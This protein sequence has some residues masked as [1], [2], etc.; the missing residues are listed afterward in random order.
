VASVWRLAVGLPE[1]H[2]LDL[3][4]LAATGAK[5]ATKPA[6]K[7]RVT[8][9]TSV[10]QGDSMVRSALV[11]KYY[12]HRVV[13]PS[14]I[15]L[16]AITVIALGWHLFSNVEAH[17]AGYIL[18]VLR[19]GNDCGARIS[20]SAQERLSH[21]QQHGNVASFA[22]GLALGRKQLEQARNAADHASICRQFVDR[23]VQA[24]ETPLLIA[25]PSL[26]Q[27]EWPF[28]LLVLL[29]AWLLLR[30]LVR[31]FNPRLLPSLSAM[32]NWPRV[33]FLLCLCVSVACVAAIVLQFPP[34][35][36]HLYRG[37]FWTG[38]RREA[39]F[40]TM[41]LGFGP[42]TT[43]IAVYV[44]ARGIIRRSVRR[45]RER[46]RIATPADKVVVQPRPDHARESVHQQDAVTLPV[47][48]RLPYAGTQ[49]PNLHHQGWGQR[50]LEGYVMP[51]HAGNRAHN[52]HHQG[53][54]IAGSPQSLVRPDEHA[55]LALA[56]RLMAARQGEQDPH[57]RAG[58]NRAAPTTEFIAKRD[59][60]PASP[61]LRRDLKGRSWRG[62][63]ANI[64]DEDGRWSPG[65]RR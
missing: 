27:L 41:L 44:P 7:A 65:R 9:E 38:T 2:H 32:K 16:V 50:N 54:N 30:S 8:A 26:S 23:Y 51:P 35:G 13:V 42:L 29:T 52:L 58:L 10:D 25:V 31:T 57:R 61:R 21:Y 28:W 45:E 14:L 19:S 5:K 3:L 59:V 47:T 24:S 60:P 40:P 43:F 4:V 63:L 15:V 33:I 20:S 12:R 39:L 62:L 56:Q 17:R 6:Q 64:A 34:D 53:W 55:V 48:G 49:A 1:S 36:L 11:T 18:G 37:Y 22:A 46:N